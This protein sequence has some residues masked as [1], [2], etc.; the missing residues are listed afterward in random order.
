MYICV[1]VYIYIYYT[2]DCL[3]A[4]LCGI[5]TGL[6]FVWG[7]RI[8]KGQVPTPAPYRPFRMHLSHGGVL[9][10]HQK[11]TCIT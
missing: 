10:S 9:P 2:R 8:A 6:L 11:S 7:P 4:R 3:D 5:V 1:Y